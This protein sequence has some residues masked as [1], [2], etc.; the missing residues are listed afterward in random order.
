MRPEFRHSAVAAGRW[1]SLYRMH[2][3]F[4]GLLDAWPNSFGIHNLF[5]R[6]GSKGIPRPLKEWRGAASA[7]YSRCDRSPMLRRMAALG[8]FKTLPGWRHNL[9][10]AA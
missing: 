7:A 10:L 1:K 5:G 8:R 6:K 2:T 4:K 9:P 3:A